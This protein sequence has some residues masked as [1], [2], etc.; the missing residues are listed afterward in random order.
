MVLVSKDRY[1]SSFLEA[2]SSTKDLEPSFAEN[3]L[4]TNL[5]IVA[6]KQIYIPPFSE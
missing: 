4:T 3:A 6:R 2:D 1:S 5:V